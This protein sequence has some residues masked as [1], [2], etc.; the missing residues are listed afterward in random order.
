MTTSG[1]GGGSGAGGAE[2]VERYKVDGVTYGVHRAATIF[3]SLT[4]R[5]F[6]ELVK[7]VAKNGLREPVCV[8][9]LEIVD[10]RNRL[11]AAL[12][13]GTPV[14]FEV[15]GD[16]VDLYGF[17]ASKNL[18]RRHLTP[19]QLAMI[20]LDLVRLSAEERELHMRRE[21]A[22]KANHASGADSGSA[23]AASSGDRPPASGM[24]Q[25]PPSAEAGTAAQQPGPAST[26]ENASGGQHARPATGG[27]PSGQLSRLPPAPSQQVKPRPPSSAPEPL[28]QKRA[29]DALGVSRRTVS[30]AAGI[31]KKTPD[32]EAA[33]RDGTLTLGDADAIRSLTKEER[34]QAIED[35]KAGKSRT[36][37]RAVS[38]P[39]PGNPTLKDTT[40]AEPQA[41]GVA[42]G[43]GPSQPP[44]GLAAA[45]T[46]HE[47]PGTVAADLLSPDVVLQSVRLALGNIDLAPCSSEA[48]QKMVR[49]R[50][51]CGAGKD[52]LTR[53]WKGSVHVF[54]PQ[55]SVSAFV[56]KLLEELDAGRV[57][58]AALLAPLDLTESWPDRIL[59]HERLSLVVIDNGR[60]R[61]RLE[62]TTDTRTPAGRMTLFLF[63]IN[64]PAAG[65]LDKLGAWGHVLLANGRGATPTQ[66]IVSGAKGLWHKA[67]QM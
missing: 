13:A 5:E 66:R 7:D 40:A 4:E 67:T 39:N 37:K 12:E 10:G 33:V 20:A 29:A 57:T 21:G 43:E 19:S 26:T 46:R 53:P 49:A 52:G 55:D 8:R 17:V 56:V 24:V 65:L 14:R 64:E 63:G 23:G 35:V 16:D 44:P 15:I 45:I 50:T 41:S 38:P 25:S 22:E 18:H 62:G 58:R 54:P 60:G 48:A 2:E 11:R 61:Y 6:D 31:V 42:A 27:S 28:T 36:A 3:P 59:A 32:L 9:G 34:E 30:R 1:D 51:W 47:Q